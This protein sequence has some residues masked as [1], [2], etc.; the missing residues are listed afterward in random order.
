MFPCVTIGDRD[1]QQQSSATILFFCGSHFDR[2]RQFR[3]FGHI[4]P[5]LV[6]LQAVSFVFCLARI[7]RS[8]DPDWPT[9]IFFRPRHH[10]LCASASLLLC[11]SA[12]LLFL[13]LRYYWHSEWLTSE[14]LPVDMA[15]AIPL[16]L[17]P[18]QPSPAIVRSIDFDR[19]MFRLTNRFR[20]V[21]LFFIDLRIRFKVNRLPNTSLHLAPLTFLVAASGW[22]PR[23]LIVRCRL[24][25]EVNINKLAF[26]FI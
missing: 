15:S 11:R 4:P 14:C 8:S 2:N 23:R 10:I 13:I 5:P 17:M 20:L 22:I 21:Q 19:F 6:A 12:D 9:E 25:F 1:S 26:E 16:L 24:S 18:S 3:R 7:H